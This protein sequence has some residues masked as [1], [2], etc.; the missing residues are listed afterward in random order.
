MKNLA[1]SLEQNLIQL[2][3]VEHRAVYKTW[4]MY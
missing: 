3:W 2:Q 1:G 4:Q